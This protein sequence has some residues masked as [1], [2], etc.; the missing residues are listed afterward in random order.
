[1]KIK[2]IADSTCD[3]SPE[4]VRKHNIRITPLSITIGDKI[5]KDGFEVSPKE[6]FDYVESGKGICHTSAVNVAEYNRVY[7]EERKNYDA[8][9]QFTISSDMS[10]C[11]QNACIAAENFS[12]VYVID[13]RNLST[14]I[15]H[16]VLDGAELI[17]QGMPAEEIY[18]ELTQRASLLDASFII[19]TLK[20]LHKGGRCSA[21][22]ALS[23]VMLQIKPCILVEDG[24]MAVG[25]KYR[26]H[27]NYVLNKYIQD[28]LGDAEDIDPRRA[29][30]THTLTEANHGLV[31]MV[32]ETAAKYCDFKE[33]YETSAGCT[34]ANH[35]GPNTLGILFFR[36]TKKG[37]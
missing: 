35:C 30:I 11:Y 28:K 19:D 9:I 12:N 1:M 34:V 24:K 31:D 29:F 6:I 5:L 2:L 20:Y 18:N 13:S 26:G 21:I 17:A 4:L 22:A 37:T 3:L 27:L 10:S 36:K 8:I 16:L 33:I 7:E 15:G 32:K 23:S 25:K 14:A